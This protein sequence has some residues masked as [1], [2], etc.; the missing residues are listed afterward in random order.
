MV[1]KLIVF[2][3]LDLSLFWT[4]KLMK[5]KNLY[6]N[7]EIMNVLDHISILLS[8]PYFHLSIDRDSH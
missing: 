2:L 3:T 8:Y 6:Q 5:L 4:Q 1:Q 7:G